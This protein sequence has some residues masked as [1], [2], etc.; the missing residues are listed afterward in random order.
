MPLLDT[1]TEYPFK[2]VFDLK[3]QARYRRKWGGNLQV[4]PPHS[5]NL[6]D[7]HQFSSKNNKKYSF[8][9]EFREVFE[10]EIGIFF[11]A[12]E[13][14]FLSAKRALGRIF[15]INFRLFF[16]PELIGCSCCVE[17]ACYAS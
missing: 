11:R 7:L 6:L 16:V 12:L 17:T 8:C 10:N 14:G 13:S 3:C 9:A 2:W 4:P 15:L 5:A 1:V